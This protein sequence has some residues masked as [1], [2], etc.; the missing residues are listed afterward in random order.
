MGQFWK[1]MG[2]AIGG[3]TKPFGDA[4]GLT[5]PAKNK[6]LDPYEEDNRSEQLQQINR[7]NVTAQGKGP[8]GS[9]M[10]TQDSTMRTQAAAQSLAGASR[11][12]AQGAL[13]QRA[14]FDQAAVG[15]QR[16]QAG[17]EAAR[18]AEM[19]AARALAARNTEALRSQDA[20]QAEIKYGVE[21]GNMAAV[22]ARQAERENN[23]IA[24]AESMA[25]ALGDYQMQRDAAKADEEE[26]ETSVLDDKQGRR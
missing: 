23:R 4:L 25:N 3:A 9:D 16:V 6:Y 5:D 8:M 1:N 10:Q 7:L 12:T 24:A 20:Y 15:T 11:G 2:K 14:A 17:G 13:A 21:S 19:S 26:E 22:T 18:A